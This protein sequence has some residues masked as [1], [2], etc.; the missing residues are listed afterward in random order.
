[1]TRFILFAFAASLLSCSSP[2]SN[3]ALITGELKNGAHATIH[4]EMITREGDVAVDSTVADANGKFTLKNNATAL[5][6]YLLRTDNQNVAYLILK[7]GE[8]ISFT[9]DAKDLE[10]TYHVEGSP[11]TRLLLD[12]KRREQ[13]LSDSMNTLYAGIRAAGP[14]EK[15]IAG[16]A[17]QRQYDSL[18]RDFALRLVQNNLSSI[19]SLSASQ[20]LDKQK[21][22]SLLVELNDSL[23]KSLGDNKYLEVFSKQIEDMKKLPVGSTAP[24]ISMRS[25]EGKVIALSSLKGKIV[26]IDFW[27]SWCGPC[28][29][30]MPEM[31]SLYRD[32]KNKDVEIY[33]VSLDDNADAWKSAIAHDGINWVHVSDLKKWESKAAA[34]YGVDEI[35]HT[36]LLDK[37]GKIVARGLGP[38]ELRIRIQELLVRGS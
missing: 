24:E 32:F 11:D 13:H 25:P 14:A 37:E 31:V 35:P 7:G 20:Y 3:T 10:R 17:L 23:K 26:I 18:L 2:K 5:D 4:F 9:G 38:H 6:Y 16:A 30:E 1:M 27:A 28:R 21:D 15:D 19:V 34:D 12:L 22:F 36:I 8:N 29:R 33:G